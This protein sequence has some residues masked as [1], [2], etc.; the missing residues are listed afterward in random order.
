MDIQEPFVLKFER[1]GGF[2]G[3]PTKVEIDSK[4]L[5]PEEAENLKQ[6]V[7]RADLLDVEKENNDRASSMSDQFQ[8]AITIEHGGQHQTVRFNKPTVPES[9][10][11]LIDYLTQKARLQRNNG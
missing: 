11:P 5:P 1:A 10:Q 3:I 9:F 7:D 2:T 6:F 8:Y 4:S